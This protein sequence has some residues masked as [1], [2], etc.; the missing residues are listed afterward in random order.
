MWEEATLHQLIVKRLMAACRLGPFFF[1][2]IYC[3]ESEQCLK[4]FLV[5]PT[6]FFCFL[7]DR[8]R[9]NWIFPLV[10]HIT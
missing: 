5:I 1:L 3:G 6:N 2:L 7:S 10:C 9:D 4:P 8:A